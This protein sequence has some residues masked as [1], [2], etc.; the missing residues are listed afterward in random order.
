M[1][2]ITLNLA[3]NLVP[4]TGRIDE[5]ESLLEDNAPYQRI[6]GGFLLLE[7]THLERAFEIFADV[8][9]KDSGSHESCVGLAEVHREREEFTEADSYM[10]RAIALFPQ[11]SDSPA[12]H[13][14]ITYWL[15]R[16]KPEK[17]RA[18]VQ[19]SATKDYA[20]WERQGLLA[21]A[22]RHSELLGTINQIRRS[23]GVPWLTRCGWI[24]P[25][26]ILALA[27]VFL[28]LKYGRKRWRCSAT[29]RSQ[30]PIGE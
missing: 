27:L 26:V 20:I 18:W 23:N 29:D 10:E 25:A 15:L 5:L 21:K 17:A 19:K 2:R 7:S 22:A 14:M 12:F 3:V 9:E 6:H 28:G 8:L 11:P 13:H 4:S 24:S 1:H 16:G 30:P